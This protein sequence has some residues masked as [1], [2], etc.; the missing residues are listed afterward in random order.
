MQKRVRSP[1]ESPKFLRNFALITSAGLGLPLTIALLPRALGYGDA[2]LHWGR[3]GVAV[4]PTAFC[5]I[6]GYFILRLIYWLV[7]ISEN[8]Q[9]AE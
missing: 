4:L 2:D 9:N 6:M 3:I 1:L 5:A 8:E 7:P